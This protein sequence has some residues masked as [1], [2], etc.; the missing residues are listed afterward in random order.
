MSDASAEVAEGDSREVET[1]L[2]RDMSLFNITFALSRN[3]T[4]R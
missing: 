2:S 3:H 4:R 1:E